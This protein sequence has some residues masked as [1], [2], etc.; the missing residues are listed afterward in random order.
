VNRKHNVLIF[1]P[2]YNER[3][4]I[5]RLYQEIKKL[6]HET[7]ILFLDDNS[8]DGTGKIIDAIVAQD[9]SCSAIHRPGK[10]GLG[11]AH[12]EAFRFAHK[13]DFQYLLTMD[14]DF[15][16]HPHYIPALIAQRE[17]ADIVIGSRYTSGGQMHGW[18]KIRLPFT[19]FWRG[20]I[21]Y[22]LGMPYDCTGAFRLYKVKQLKPELYDSLRSVGFSFCMESLYYL[23]KNGLQISEVPIRANNRVAGKSK[24]STTIMSE[25]AG[26]YCKL[27][28]DRI[29]SIG[30]KKH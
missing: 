17:K 20:M 13:H 26:M 2:T 15:T 24:L 29:I 19:Y 10:M 7:N 30:A 14:A 28:F 8:P 5:E 21:K 3:D 16:H 4:N 12:K 18:G 25:V 22:G 6:S 9:P 23:K 27:L 1:I 11:T